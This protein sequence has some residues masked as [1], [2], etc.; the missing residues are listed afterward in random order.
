MIVPGVES[1]NIGIF[2]LPNELQLEIFDCLDFKSRFVASNVCRLWNAL[3]FSGRFMDRIGLSLDITEDSLK[4]VVATLGNSVRNYRHVVI[5]F[6]N[7]AVAMMDMLSEN[8]GANDALESLV[9][10]GMDR[11]ESVQL[12]ML[13]S[14][15][16]DLVRLYLLGS[17]PQESQRACF[18]ELGFREIP[19]S[20]Y[21][22]N[23]VWM[24]ALSTDSQIEL[25]HVRK[26]CLV[27]PSRSSLS[28]ECFRQKFPNLT[29]IQLI[30]DDPIIA[31]LLNDYR[32]QLERISL[33]TPSSYFFIAF[34]EIIFL[35]LADLVVDRM[36]LHDQHVVEKCIK[37]FKN[38]AHSRTL[39]QLIL[40]PKFMI[41][42]PIFST[43]CANCSSLRVLELS[44]DYMDGDA[45]KE[46]TNLK[47]LQKLSLQ[48]T[49][50]F[51]ETPRW[52]SQI[53]TL[54]A[55]RI[56]GS[57]FPI[58]VL[59]FIADIAPNLDSLAL[60]NLEHPQ[61]MFRILPMLVG[62]IRRFA[63]GYSETFE[64]PPS[65]HPSGFLRSMVGL[66]SFSLRRVVIKH[67][68]QGWLQ[69]APH[70]RKVTLRDCDTLTD[71]H[72]V[73]LTTN[74]PKLKELELRRCSAVTASGVAQFRSKMPLCN[75]DSD[76]ET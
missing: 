12:V 38:L 71:T 32:C 10:F 49:A 46:V 24:D 17:K 50:Y 1:C 34:S 52:P 25:H 75:V 55:V 33:L 76:H 27:S 60:E 5:N 35:K 36:E 15:V 19:A 68:I 47:H 16:P 43:I 30:C 23:P 18:T 74:C 40:H 6:N 65:C 59:E 62:S 11:I 73:I 45:L 13:L 44:L 4:S 2:D 61:D 31:T 26:L 70:L 63:I 8:I 22:G 51:R 69:D 9:L 56:C 29:Q 37:F 72:L 21:Y 41:R 28:P 64:R 57:R 42:T 54:K 7:Q 20:D 48:G 39:R 58:S 53:R 66:E 14:S 3:A 67:G